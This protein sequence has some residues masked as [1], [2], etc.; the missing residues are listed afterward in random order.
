METHEVTH[1]D[2]YLDVITIKLINYN[3]HLDGRAIEHY[4]KQLWIQRGTEW[5]IIINQ[6][7]A[8]QNDDFLV[9]I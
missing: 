2:E 6:S 9:K 8:F 7:S 1:Q 5:S 3:Y 4:L